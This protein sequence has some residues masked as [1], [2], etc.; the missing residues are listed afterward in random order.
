LF[1]VSW[2]VGTN[3]TGARESAVA[4]EAHLQGPTD[5][6]ARLHGQ[7]GGR[8]PIPIARRLDPRVA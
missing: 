5:P 6:D 8:R 1:D 2:V 7:R 4:A 3:Q